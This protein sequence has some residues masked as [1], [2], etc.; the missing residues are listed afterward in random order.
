MPIVLMFKFF[1]LNTKYLYFSVDLVVD[2]I[3]FVNVVMIT[4]LHIKDSPIELYFDLCNLKWV[5][6]F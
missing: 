5:C 6:T 2:Y 1:I 4:L 3:A